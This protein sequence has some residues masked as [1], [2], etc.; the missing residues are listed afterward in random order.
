M[1]ARRHEMPF[2]AQLL[3]DGRVRF[4]L[5]APAAA[6]VELVLEPAEGR[7]RILPLERAADGFLELVT[8]EAHAGSLY[9]YRIDGE[10]RVPDP[11]SR[12]NP[13]GVHGPSEVVDPGAFPWTDDGWRA[14]AW[15]EAVVYELHV[16]TFTPEGT[17]AGVA[18]KLEHLQRLGVTVIELMPLAEFPGSRGWGYDGVLPYA[19]ASPYGTPRDLKS[20]VCAAHAHGIAMMLDVVYNH[21]GPEGNFLHR[22]APQFF[23]ERH[24]TPWGAAIDFEDPGSRPVR[25]FFI[26]NALYWLE[27]YHLDG[28]RLDA[29]HAIFD[30]SE[31]HILTEIARAARSGPGRERPVY[32]VLENFNNEAR[33]L[34][35]ADT[36]GRSAGADPEGGEAPARE[37]LGSEGVEAAFDAQWNDD[38]HHCLH[39]LLT[40]ESDGYY[41]D[42]QANPHRLLCRSLAEGFVYQGEP[43]SSGERPR[44]MRGQGALPPGM[45]SGSGERPRTMRG[46]GA[47]PPGMA[48]GT[49]TGKTRGEPSTHLPPSAFV[50]FLQNHDQVG[51]RARGERLAQLT[52]IE[53]LRA[54]AA[55]LLLA[56]SPPMLFMGEEW[57]AREPFPYFC[58]FEP[59][60]AQKVRAGRLREFAHFQGPIPDPCEADTFASAHLDWTR[61]TK[62]PHA[63]MF[64]HYRRLL[65]IRRRDIVPLLP[66]I[67]G[68]ACVAL[69]ADGAFAVD[70]RLRDHGV[71]HL[72]ANL[73]DR[74]APVVGRPAGRMIFATHPGIRAAISRNELAPWSVT[75]LL[76]R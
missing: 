29:V 30:G 37:G 75:W 10:L 59:E 8:A 51:N 28:L 74:S 38:Y 24:S 21:F 67:G 65:A 72:L 70:W 62:P 44:T 52:R 58:D 40:G 56:P 22:Y 13:Q 69:D 34:G 57:A 73:R 43:L 46:Q 9:R 5:W 39:V 68:G 48:D 53:A 47:P 71:L 64:D 20:L 36:H 3:P 17:F 49:A 23:T 54:A 42:Y 55:V 45:A 50:N 32:L 14:P 31:P 26:H 66:R 41:E 16:G 1:T 35:P 76:E 7:E 12:R 2:G 27:E 11:A 25:E 4:R 15:R 63:R 19:P 33:R 61:L 6:R 60:L 18:R